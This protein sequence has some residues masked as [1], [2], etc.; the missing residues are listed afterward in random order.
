MCGLDFVPK[1]NLIFARKQATENESEK[2]K[3]WNRLGSSKTNH[4]NLI[5]PFGYS[6]SCVIRTYTHTLIH[7]FPSVTCKLSLDLDHRLRCNEISCSYYYYCHFRL[8]Y[9]VVSKTMATSAYRQHV[10]LGLRLTP[11]MT[12][13]N[14]YHD[15]HLLNH[16][17]RTTIDHRAMIVDPPIQ[18]YTLPA[19]F[20]RT[21]IDVI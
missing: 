20:Q 4:R 6:S 9:D 21:I 14:R 5:F 3:E 11:M 2:L 10:P 16:L 17:D 12:Y 15:V 19:T 1:F 8:P 13:V 18:H 7:T